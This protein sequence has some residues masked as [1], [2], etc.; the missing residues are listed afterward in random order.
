[1]LDPAQPPGFRWLHD[2]FGTNAR[3][4]EVQ[5]SV[6][7]CQLRKVDG[8]VAARRAHAARLTAGLDDLGALRLPRIPASVGHAF[9]RYHLQLRTDQ[10]DPGWNRDRV[11]A[12]V[13]A[14]G[15]PATVGG[16]VEIHRERAFRAAGIPSRAL[17][18]AAALSRTSMTLPVHQLMSSSDIDDVLAA[19]RKVLREAGR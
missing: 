1:M 2:S 17:P 16:C 12:A 6:G 5:A 10:L 4:T 19:V 14:E 7:R 9:Y 15:V 8:W 13:V 3:M 11:V 18:Q